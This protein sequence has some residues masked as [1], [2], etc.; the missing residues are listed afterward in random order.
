MPCHV[1]WVPYKHLMMIPV[2]VKNFAMV[3]G[4]HVC[5]C[6]ILE[7]SHSCSNHHRTDFKNQSNVNNLLHRHDYHL[8][9]E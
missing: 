1:N 2:T 9:Q 3:N 4:S 7:G 5:T 8:G 6:N